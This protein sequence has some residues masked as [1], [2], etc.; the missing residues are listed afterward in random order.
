[1]GKGVPRIVFTASMFPTIV[2]LDIIFQLSVNLSV[3]DFLMQTPSLT[4]L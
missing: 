2:I 3:L 1:M 4:Q